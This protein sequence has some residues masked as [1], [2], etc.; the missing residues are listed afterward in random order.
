MKAWFSIAAAILLMVA[1]ILATDRWSDGHK[2]EGRAVSK[3][4]SMRSQRVRD[5]REPTRTPAAVMPDESAGE[6]GVMPVP[7]SAGMK[8]DVSSDP[9]MKTHRNSASIPRGKARMPLFFDLEPDELSRR[10]PQ[11]PAEAMATFREEF[12]SEVGT[13]ELDPEDPASVDRWTR[14]EMSLEQRI[15]LFYGWQAWGAYQHQLAIQDYQ[16]RRARGNP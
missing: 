8:P 7:G 12:I 14:A 3:L 10:L 13:A 11:I 15:R 9:G 4:A 6:D 5:H 16:E 2:V 1:A